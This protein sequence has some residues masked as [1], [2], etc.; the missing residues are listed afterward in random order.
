MITLEKE[1]G[2]KVL[3]W[4]AVENEA[5][6]E[7]KTG[8]KGKALRTISI[9]A[10]SCAEGV[11]NYLR[12]LATQQLRNGFELSGESEGSVSTF[13]LAVRAEAA[14]KQLKED[15]SEIDTIHCSW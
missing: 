4:Q 8:T 11:A 3:I 12:K 13:V 6:L 10:A 15:L 14:N 5:G 1:K 7:I 2:S 9:P